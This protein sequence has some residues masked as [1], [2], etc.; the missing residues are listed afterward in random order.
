M[1]ITVKDTATPAVEAIHA[2]IAEGLAPVQD[3]LTALTRARFA[4]EFASEGYGAWPP[5]AEE[6]RRRH[7]DEVLG[8]FSGTLWASLAEEGA[9]GLT[10][11]GGASARAFGFS[12][13]GD[14][15]RSLTV[16]TSDPVAHLFDAGTIHQP[17]RPLVP[18]PW[19]PEDAARMGELLRGYLLTGEVPS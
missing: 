15:G 5:L 6:T 8:E 19:P 1:T 9:T 7:P 3:A 10:K 16:G 12:E 13:L 14:G 2:R 4:D 18:D 11:R 17:A